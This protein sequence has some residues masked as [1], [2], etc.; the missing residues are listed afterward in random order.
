M[1]LRAA[2]SAVT[3]AANGVDLRDP[4]EACTSGRLPG[5]YV[6]LAVGESHDR[7]VEAGL[8]VGLADRNVLLDL[9]ASAGWA[10][11]CWH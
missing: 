2:A 6:A 1:P 11:W 3:W 9:A 5:Y 10:F 8:D 4:L 7:I